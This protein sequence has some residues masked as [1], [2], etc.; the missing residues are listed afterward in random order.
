MF[1]RPDLKII[2]KSEQNVV[3]ICEKYEYFWLH[4]H[5]PKPPP[6]V[7]KRNHLEIPSP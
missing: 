4:D 6:L 3:K 5:Q 7:I 1:V 2:R